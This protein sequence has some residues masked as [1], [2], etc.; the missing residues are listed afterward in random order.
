V[1]H[2][3][4]MKEFEGPINLEDIFRIKA[5]PLL[6]KAYDKGYEACLSRIDITTEKVN[7][8]FHKYMELRIKDLNDYGF[9]LTQTERDAAEEAWMAC[10]E[11]LSRRIRENN[12]DA[13]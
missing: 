11:F 9:D 2:E 13:V 7:T 6:S 4:E 3:N 8:E 10:W 5:A 1:T 12:H